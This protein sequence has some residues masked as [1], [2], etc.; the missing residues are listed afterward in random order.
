MKLFNTEPSNLLISFFF[1]SDAIGDIGSQIDNQQVR[2]NDLFLVL[3]HIFRPI[4][5][6][7]YLA[8]LITQT[9]ESSSLIV[10]PKMKE[11]HSELLKEYNRNVIKHFVKCTLSAHEINNT[12][13]EYENILPYSDIS[14]GSNN[15]NEELNN[16]NSNNNTL[17]NQLKESSSKLVIRSPFVALSGHNDEFETAQELADTCNLALPIELDQIPSSTLQDIRGNHMRLNAYA[18]DFLKHGNRKSLVHENGFKEANAWE[19]IRDWDEI[20]EKLTTYLSVLPKDD[21]RVKRVRLLFD[22]LRTDF[23]DKFERFNS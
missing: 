20:L 22:F 18:W 16:N 7:S 17:L 10:L 6:T 21:D 8:S 9:D 11:N 14:I 1:L 12:V 4:P 2:L 5:V 15:N 13:S 19:L 23:H 3:C